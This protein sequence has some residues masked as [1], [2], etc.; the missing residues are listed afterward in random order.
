MKAIQTQGAITGIRSK[1]DRS[2][3]LTLSTPELST[4]E[5]SL[6]ME[7]QGVECSI[8]IQPL[9][10]TDIE[11]EKIDG[12]IRTKTQSQRL[13]GVLFV[14]WQQQGKQGEFEEFYRAQT[15]KMIEHY[16]AKLDN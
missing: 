1:V 8:L 4:N 2:L 14:L 13:R 6:F 10:S 15:E 12:E 5:R 9:D 16:K 3:G 7:L 11:P